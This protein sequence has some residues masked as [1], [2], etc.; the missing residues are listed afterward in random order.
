MA[1]QVIQRIE[2]SIIMAPIRRCHLQEDPT[3]EPLY[4]FQDLRSP[5]LTDQSIGNFTVQLWMWRLKPKPYFIGF[6]KLSETLCYPAKLSNNGLLFDRWA[7]I[8]FAPTS[9]RWR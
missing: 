5:S 6:I 4:D 2:K 1:L 9:N 7:T 3:V 8:T